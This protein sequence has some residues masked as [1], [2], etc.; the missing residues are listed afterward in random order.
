MFWGKGDSSKLAE[1]E[2]QTLARL[3]RL[4]ETGHLTALTP[5]KAQIAVRGVDFYGQMEGVLKLLNSIK[6]VSVMVG[7]L[8]AVWWATQ[9]QITAWIGGMAAQATGTGQ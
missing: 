8:L 1:G 2:Q 4:E 5:E 3:R 6:N 9:G 7:A